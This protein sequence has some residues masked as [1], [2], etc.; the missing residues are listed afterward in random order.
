MYGELNPIP[1]FYIMISGVHYVFSVARYLGFKWN[2]IAFMWLHLYLQL[3]NQMIMIWY[4]DY[5]MF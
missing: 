2:V 1:D 5:V 3:L 4:S